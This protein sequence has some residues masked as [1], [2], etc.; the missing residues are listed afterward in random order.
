MYNPNALLLAHHVKQ[1]NL[2][3]LIKKAE[4]EEAAKGWLA[5]GKGLG[6][7]IRKR[8]GDAGT[9]LRGYGDAAL[10]AIKAHPYRAGGIG[11]GALGLGGLAAAYGLGAF[12]G[13]TP[14]E[15]PPPPGFDLNPLLGAGVGAGLGAGVGA[16][17]GGRS[18]KE[19]IRNALIGLAI[20]GAAGYGAGQVL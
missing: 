20:G 15:V 16:I 12:G 17:T 8:L 6:T 7:A 4:G 1:A 3:H 11:A 5:W 13:S 14:Q 10:K 9:A 2:Y 18:R 19:A